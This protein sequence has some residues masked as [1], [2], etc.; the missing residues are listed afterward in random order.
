MARRPVNFNIAD[1]REFLASLT[2]EKRHMVETMQAQYTGVLDQLTMTRE[3]LAASQGDLATLR[4]MVKEGDISA[5]RAREVMRETQS[6]TL[7][8]QVSSTDFA[9]AMRVW[10]TATSDERSML[11]PQIL[12][13]ARA[14][15]RR[16]P[17]DRDRI[18]DQ[19]KTA[20]VLQ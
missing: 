20:G 12:E 10:A 19:L 6:P 14:A 4:T 11:R 2:P 16:R 15:I 7:Q 1:Y 8:R 9:S 13:K 3:E 5:G 18:L 17:A